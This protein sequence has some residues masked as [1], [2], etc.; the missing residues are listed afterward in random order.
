MQ[1]GEEIGFQNTGRERQ[2]RHQC[3]VVLDLIESGLDR[4]ARIRLAIVVVMRRR[5][6]GI[7]IVVLAAGEKLDPRKRLDPAMDGERQPQ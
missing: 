1:F 4:R 6:F 3:G 5:L 2:N 7:G